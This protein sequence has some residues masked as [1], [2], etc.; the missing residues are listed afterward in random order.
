MSFRNL[1]DSF[2]EFKFRDSDSESYI[3][4]HTGEHHFIPCKTRELFES[5]NG[6]SQLEQCLIRNSSIASSIKGDSRSHTGYSTPRSS[7]SV[8]FDFHL[9]GKSLAD[10]LEQGINTPNLFS[11]VKYGRENSRL[12]QNIIQVENVEA[13]VGVPEGGSAEITLEEN[14]FEELI[15]KPLELS[16]MI[17]I[18]EFNNQSTQETE[19]KTIDQTQ[20]KEEEAQ[21][22]QAVSNITPQKYFFLFANPTKFFYDK[23]SNE[24]HY[25]IRQLANGF[26]GVFLEKAEWK[27]ENNRFDLKAL[28]SRIYL[29]ARKILSLLYNQIITVD[30]LNSS[31]IENILAEHEE[32]QVNLPA[33]VQKKI[34]KA[35][36][37][38]EDY[39]LKNVYG[40]KKHAYKIP[41]AEELQKAF[42]I[43]KGS[44]IQT[45]I[46]SIFLKIS[47]RVLFE[48]FF[49]NKDLY[50]ALVDKIIEHVHVEVDKKKKD[51]NEKL[52]ELKKI[53]Y[54]VNR[55]E[56]G[57]KFLD[58]PFNIKGMKV[59]FKYSIPYD[60]IQPL[61][62]DFL[63][64][65]QRIHL[66]DEKQRADLETPTALFFPDSQTKIDARKDN[67]WIAIPFLTQRQLEKTENALKERNIPVMTGESC[68]ELSV[69]FEDSVE[70]PTMEFIEDGETLIKYRQSGKTQVKKILINKATNIEKTKSKNEK[71]VNM[72]S[73]TCFKRR[74][75][76]LY[77]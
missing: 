42:L 40:K 46:S 77:E 23:M 22:E 12:D 8:Y 29:R 18:E 15:N 26:A 21:E 67:F 70:K 41:N 71:K 36:E 61:A 72:K 74:L 14:P 47:L 3:S 60:E 34:T 68:E 62:C 32:E 24:R 56:F 50:N 33:E 48:Q 7:G 20:K 76:D 53:F 51:T 55:T 9:F 52:P 19:S 66:F 35:E 43:N 49:N 63:D 11:P 45:H 44:D 6:S 54:K 10:R 73:T 30:E 59:A 39:I 13:R 27:L 16:H 64:M 37:S 5:Y 69:D 4:S 25:Y 57:Q 31:K 17:S 75:Q 38:F 28:K 65:T 1:I 58:A 2:K